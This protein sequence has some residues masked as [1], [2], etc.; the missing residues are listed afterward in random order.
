MTVLLPSIRFPLLLHELCAIKPQA[1]LLLVPDTQG[2]ASHHRHTSSSSSISIVH[3]P[4]HMTLTV[5]VVGDV[6][7][8]RTPGSLPAAFDL[9]LLPAAPVHVGTM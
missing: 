5:M 7:E 3:K 2:M 1:D 6:G 4:I 8:L 9:Q